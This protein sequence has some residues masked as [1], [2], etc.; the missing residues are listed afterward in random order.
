MQIHNATAGA[1]AQTYT[2]Q[3]AARTGDADRSLLRPAAG[4]PRADSVS[5]STTTQEL[6]R[7]RNVASAQPD[8][9]AERVAALKAAIAGGSYQVDTGLLAG[10][11]LG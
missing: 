7:L 4:R 10:R 5:L 6:M 2:R 8:V 9:R 3:T 1:I 11:L